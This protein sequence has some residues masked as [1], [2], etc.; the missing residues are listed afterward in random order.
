[1]YI[2]IKWQ[3][4]SLLTSKNV[5]WIFFDKNKTKN[6]LSF[7]VMSMSGRVDSIVDILMFLIVLGGAS[8][9]NSTIGMSY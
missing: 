7:P 9:V 3:G 6:Y 1:M 5:N 2:N 4:R 8:F